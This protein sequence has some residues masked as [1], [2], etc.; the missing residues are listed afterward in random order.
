MD[1]QQ[2][3]PS[4]DWSEVDKVMIEFGSFTQ[5]L[6]TLEH[7]TIIHDDE[8]GIGFDVFRALWNLF[9]NTPQMSE[10]Y[11]IFTQINPTTPFIEINSHLRDWYN[12][13]MHAVFEKFISQDVDKSKPLYLC[14]CTERGDEYLV[15]RA[16]IN[17][18]LTDRAFMLLNCEYSRMKNCDPRNKLRSVRESSDI[19]GEYLLAVI[20][21][22]SDGQC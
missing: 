3:N 2:V 1:S 17:D 15:R 7:T 21:V 16:C 20:H 13:N 19:P 14:V 10:K 6:V 22:H 5:P 9:R 18:T 11:P 8:I 12:K 4:C